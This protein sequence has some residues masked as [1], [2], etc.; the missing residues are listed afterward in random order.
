MLHTLIQKDV[1][2]IGDLPSPYDRRSGT[3]CENLR[4]TVYPSSITAPI[5]G[6]TECA[7]PLDD[8]DKSINIPLSE[9]FRERRSDRRKSR[10]IE[11]KFRVQNRWHKGAIRNI[12]DG[13]AYISSIRG[14][15]FLLGEEIFLFAQIKG[16]YGGARAKISWVGLNSM[17]V[18]F[19]TERS[20]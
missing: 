18:T 19:Q 3:E 6:G 1:Q 13:G 4:E 12:S 5:E 9:S 10:F 17:G 15:R 8:P 2:T 11:A 20:I 7:H 14:E 16:L